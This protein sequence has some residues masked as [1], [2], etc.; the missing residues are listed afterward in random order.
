MERLGSGSWSGIGEGLEGFKSGVWGREGQKSWG[1][2]VEGV[3]VEV[4]ES[5]W[6][7]GGWNWEVGVRGIEVREV[8]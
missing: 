6:D 5:S 4:E 8:Y 1:V 3:G 2:G 7:W